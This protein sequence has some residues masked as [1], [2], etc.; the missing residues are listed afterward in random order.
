MQIFAFRQFK[1]FD[2]TFEQLFIK[3]WIKSGIR[4]YIIPDG[5]AGMMKLFGQEVNIL[6]EGRL[7]LRDEP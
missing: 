6:K 1:V 5:D 2:Q 3:A 7:S 4:F